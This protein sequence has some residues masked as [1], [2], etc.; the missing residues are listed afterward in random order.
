MEL[1]GISP[2]LHHSG[3]HET[4]GYATQENMMDGINIFDIWIVMIDELAVP[5][6][7]RFVVRGKCI[8]E[9]QSISTEFRAILRM[10]RDPLLWVVGWTEREQRR[11]AFKSEGYRTVERWRKSG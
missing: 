5:T 10:A 8:R 9:R 2:G 3:F 1:L 4:R 11:K 7:F 6:V